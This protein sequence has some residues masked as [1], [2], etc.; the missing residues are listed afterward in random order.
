[1][2]RLAP[3]G[4]ELGW[5]WLQR[6]H[7]PRSWLSHRHEL[8]PLPP[9][10]SPRAVLPRRCFLSEAGFL[11]PHVQWFGAPPVR[12]AHCQV[13]SSTL[14]WRAM[15]LPQAQPHSI[16]KKASTQRGPLSFSGLPGPASLSA[17]MEPLAVSSR[18]CHCPDGQQLAFLSGCQMWLAGR[19]AGSTRQRGQCI[20]P[21]PG[22]GVQGRNAFGWSGG[23]V[24][25]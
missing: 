22:A 15:P 16:P 19:L 7:V 23:V 10:Q 6:G 8:S 13:P 3:A 14:A 12:G 2:I 20:G 25:E 21:G 4:L 11:S 9:S 17:D 18:S 5:R 1:M 24:P